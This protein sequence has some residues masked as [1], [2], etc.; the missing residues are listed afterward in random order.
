MLHLRPLQLAGSS[1][2]W[3]SYRHA[4]PTEWDFQVGPLLSASQG[5]NHSVLRVLI[6]SIPQTLVRLV[7]FDI[8]TESCML[9][10]SKLRRDIG[11]YIVVGSLE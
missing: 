1:T 5:H 4:D 7:D 6:A 8:V 2:F 9:D 10:M 3:G 11:S